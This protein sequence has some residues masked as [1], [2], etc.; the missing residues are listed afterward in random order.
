[1]ARLTSSFT[2]LMAEIEEKTEA[3]LKAERGL[4]QSQRLASIGL[5]AA[6]VAHEIGGPLSA[7]RLQA[8]FWQERAD[9][10]V[11]TAATAVQ[12]A[13]T[14]IRKLQQELLTFDR[15]EA[16]E[17]RAHDLH[18]LLESC[19]KAPDLSTI[20]VNF[21]AAPTR[22][23][24]LA[25]A[26]ALTRA[27]GNVLSNAAEAMAGRGILTVTLRELE[28]GQV[29]ITVCDTG[30]GIPPDD[31]PHVFDPFF[32]RKGERGGSGLGLAIAREIVSRHGGEIVAEAGP[33]GARFRVFLPL[34]MDSQGVTGAG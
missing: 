7:I 8:S 11:R 17:L 29:E 30:P 2:A 33:Q 14:Q 22:F 6:G 26:S 1:M 4:L 18:A 34:L 10:A 24:L 13:A 27:L 19:L 16:L 28:S 5:L 15:R 25:D 12:D 32:T 31:L 3:L 23:L 9:G 20:T 21:E